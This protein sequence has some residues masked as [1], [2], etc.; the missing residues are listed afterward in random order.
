MDTN[1]HHEMNDRKA[2]LEEA[3]DMVC[4]HCDER[5]IFHLRD[6][7]HEFTMGLSTVLQC[8]MFAIEQGDLPKLPLSWCTDVDL[9]Y[10]TGCS[11]DER[12]FYVDDRNNQTSQNKEGL[13]AMF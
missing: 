2:V 1:N 8:L 6:C 13:K 3:E 4:N 7:E 9:A 12:Y 10:D 11:E 5:V